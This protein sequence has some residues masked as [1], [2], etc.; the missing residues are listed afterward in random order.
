MRYA[1]VGADGGST[2][3]HLAGRFHHN[4][5]KLDDRNI[6]GAKSFL[7]AVGDTSASHGFPHRDVLIGKAPDAGEIPKLHRLAILPVIVLARAEFAK[8]RIK[9][10]ADLRAAELAP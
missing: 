7:G 5:P 3:T 4:A 9:I 10:D 8:L 6:A 1:R 2:V